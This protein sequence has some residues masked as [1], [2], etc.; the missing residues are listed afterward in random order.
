MVIAVS[1]RDEKWKR[2][3]GKERGNGECMKEVGLCAG[4]ADVD[5]DGASLTFCLHPLALPLHAF[6]SASLFLP[7]P[8]FL[9]SPFHP[10]L[11][12]KLPIVQLP[13]PSPSATCIIRL[14]YSPT[15]SLDR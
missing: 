10:G 2:E 14:D 15:H 11:S 3:D 12:F 8:L 9:F 7:F 13:C 6:L 4:A 5:V 1:R